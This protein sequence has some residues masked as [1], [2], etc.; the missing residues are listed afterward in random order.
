MNIPEWVKILSTFD[1]FTASEAASVKRRFTGQTDYGP[2]VMVKLR[3][4]KGVAV[5]VLGWK[6][7]GSRYRQRL[8]QMTL[9]DE[10]EKATA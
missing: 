5:K 10:P 6:G 8:Y 2:D 7:E 3:K 1:S 9:E 4:K